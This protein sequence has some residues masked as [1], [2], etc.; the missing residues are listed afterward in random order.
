M[1]MRDILGLLSDTWDN[2][3]GYRESSCTFQDA[4]SAESG[5]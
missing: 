1:E 4:N 5:S 3:V 2:V